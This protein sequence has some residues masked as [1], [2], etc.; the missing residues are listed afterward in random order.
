MIDLGLRGGAG[1]EGRAPAAASGGRRPVASRH[2]LIL[3]AAVLTCVGCVSG[4]PVRPDDSNLTVEAHER[5]AASE[6]AHAR[7]A[8]AAGAPAGDVQAR[9]NAEAGH[10]A[11]AKALRDAEAAACA[12]VLPARAE[13]STP[14]ATVHRVEVI[15]VHAGTAPPA[16]M[17]VV[18]PDQ[19]VG[20]RMTVHGDLTAVELTALLDCRVARVR[21][22]G[23]DGSEPVAVRGATFVVHPAKDGDLTLDVRA[24]SEEG[25]REVLRR[26][27]LAA[28]R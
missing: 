13:A 15:R 12:G 9:V 23:D 5:E 20:V 24:P 10:L 19:V 22:R 6:A 26:A 18:P 17:K 3:A 8:V 28:E 1:D 21:A 4:R 16:P 7:A 25:V 2:G 14:S 27:Q 11:A